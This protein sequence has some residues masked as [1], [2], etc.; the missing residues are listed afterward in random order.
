MA[1]YYGPTGPAPLTGEMTDQRLS[2]LYIQ[3]WNE[4]QEAIRKQQEEE[5]SKEDSK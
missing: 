1:D 4:E 3:L 5:K 2:N